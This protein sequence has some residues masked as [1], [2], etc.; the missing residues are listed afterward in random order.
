MDSATVKELARSAGFDLCGISAP[1]RDDRA[2]RKYLDWLEAGYHGSM[3]WLA[4]EPERRTDPSQVLPGVKSIIMLGLN[5]FQ[6]NSQDVPAGKGRVCRYARGRDYHK[7][8]ARKI[9]ALIRALRRE[10]RSGDRPSFRWSVDFGP[11]QERTYAERAGLGFIGKNGLLINERLG[12]W[13]FLSEILTSL[14]LKPDMRNPREH[15][16]CSTCSLCLE[17]C[18]TGAIVTPRTIDAR[19]CI[20]YLTIERPPDI[21]DEL[22]QSFGMSIFGCDICQE[23]C[24]YNDAASITRH[25]EFLP[26]QGL[27]EFVDI[28]AILS[29]RTREEFLELT[30]GTALTRPR[31]EGLKR[32]AEIVRKNQS[33]GGRL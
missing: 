26:P 32:N 2:R 16:S 27:G 13:F 19:R 28:D 1:D 5:Y 24:P 20:A 11:F 23:V 15:G 3:A 10:V 9:K 25:P 22:A 4:R 29:L 8:T 18:P 17:A 31:L 33:S 30:A 7:V 6:P 12:S 14:E 21:S